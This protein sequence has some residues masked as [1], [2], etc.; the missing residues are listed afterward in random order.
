MKKLIIVFT[1][2]LSL[3]FA[4]CEI[5]NYDAPTSVLSGTVVYNGDPVGVRTNGA[6]FELWQDGY[7][8]YEKIGV[9]IA[10]DGTYSARLFNG[11]YKLVRLGGA[12]WEAQSSDTIVVDVQGDTV[13]DIEVDP[14]YT[15]SESSITVNGNTVVANFTVNQIDS[16][17]S[18]SDV[19]LFLSKRILLDDNQRDFAVDAN[20]SEVTSGQN[21]TLTATLP[22]SL[23]NEDYFFARVGVRSNKSNEFYYTQV[24]ELRG[25]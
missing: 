9:H 3:T 24:T 10:Q 14:F 13:K 18:I 7:A 20:L 19:R 17:A 25:N 2:A 4:G 1:A 5:D 22:E 6:Q 11:Q 8:L 15:I 23:A 21:V 16:D 12:P